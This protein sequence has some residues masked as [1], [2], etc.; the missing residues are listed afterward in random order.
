MSIQP[1][2][3]TIP[4]TRDAV[5]VH[6]GADACTYDPTAAMAVATEILDA[7]NL[8]LR[9]DVMISFGPIGAVHLS[10]AT[11]RDLGAA[12]ATAA[13]TLMDEAEF[14]F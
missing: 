7:A 5:A 2:T 6:I 10:S 11:A 13:G 1:I 9:R 8:P 4:E 14:S 3:V 12:I